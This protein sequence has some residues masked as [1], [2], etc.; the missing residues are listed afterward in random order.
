MARQKSRPQ[1]WADAASRAED[2]LSELVE[3][4]A[5]YEQWKDSLPENLT[6]SPVGE[7][8]E[9]VCGI[10]IQS[11]LDAASEASGADLPRGFGKD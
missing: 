10:D 6:N 1:R 11:A 9:T 8:L 5:E 7:K 2:A 4:Q 3:L